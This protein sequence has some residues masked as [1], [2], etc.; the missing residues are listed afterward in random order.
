MLVALAWS[1]LAA[2]RAA[3]DAAAREAA[4]LRAR[5]DA[6]AAQSRTSSATSAAIS[7]PR[8]ASSAAAAAA[9]R[10][11]ARRSVAR[12][13]RRCS[14]SSPAMA[15]AQGEQ[16][17]RFGERLAE[18]TRTNEQ[19]LEAVRATVEQR[20][21]A[22]RNENAAKL[23][24]MR[25]T[26]DE[27]LQTT[28]EQRLGESFKQVSERL[29]QVHKGLGEMQTLAA[30]VGDLKRVLTNV[31]TRGSWGEVQLGALLEQVLTP[32]QYAAQ[33][34]DA[35]GQR[36]ARRV[37][38]PAARAR[39]TTA[40]RA[41]CRSTP[42]SRSRTTQRLQDAQERADLRRVRSGRA[43]A[44]RVRVTRRGEDDPR[45]VRRAAAHDRFRDPVPADRGA[46][47]RG[48]ARARA[49]PTRCS[50]SYRVMVAGPTTLAALL[51]SL[52]MG[53]RTLAIEQRSS[54]VW[55]VLGAVKTEFGKFGDVL[56]KT[57]KKL[58]QASKTIDDAGVRS[59]GDRPGSCAR[60]RRCPSPRRP[61]LYGDR[62]P[63]ADGDGDGRPDDA[64]PQT[65]R[66]MFD[67]LRKWRQR[68]GA[69]DAAIPDALWREAPQALPFLA[70]YDA[71]ELDAAAR[72]GRAVPRRQGDRR[73]ARSR[74]DAAAARVIALQACV[75]VLNLDLAYYDGFENVVVYPDEFVPGWE[76]EDEAG[77]VHRQRRGARRRGDAAGP[78][79]LS[80]PDVE[81]GADWDAAGMNLVIHEFAHK[82]DMRNGEANGCPPLPAGRCRRTSGRT[83]LGAAFDH[84]RARVRSRRAHGDRSLRGRE[85][86]RVLRGAVR[87]V[88]RRPGAAFATSTRGV[89]DQFARFYRQDPAAA[90]RR[91]AGAPGVLC[92]RRSGARA[93]RITAARISAPPASCT[94]A[95]VS[96]STTAASSTVNS[97]S[98][99]DSVDARVGPMRSRP[100]KNSV[101]AATVETS[102]M[103]TTASQPP[104]VCG[105][106][107]PRHA[108]PRRRTPTAALAMTTV[109]IAQ[110]RDAAA[111]RAR[112]RRCRRRRSPP[113][114]RRTRCRQD[115]RTR[116][117][118]VAAQRRHHRQRRAGQRERQRDELRAPSAAR[119]GT[120]RREQRDQRRMQVEEQ[121]D[122]AG[123][124]ERQRREER[125]RLAAVAE[126]AQ[127]D[128]RR[129]RRA[130]RQR[131]ARAR[132]SN[133]SMTT[134]A[135]AKRSASSVVVSTPDA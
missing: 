38:D 50:A 17:Q 127:H 48:D 115:A 92:Q 65:D 111:E 67:A 35:A 32:E 80:W 77:V 10:D 42:S 106:C 29:E 61:R 22:L 36:R 83:M 18:L 112:R 110:R 25:A 95:I 117:A 73:R 129:Q 98:T 46:L 119:A 78:V 40:R 118:R 15:T 122:E 51:N 41:G 24:Q 64:E 16:L 104:A 34:R 107:G 33:R 69:A 6:L 102:A 13:R 96:P 124:G 23:E 44:R 123:R 49:S 126:R 120:A 70:I 45:Q 116:A 63:P 9:A 2:L 21:D 59:A 75:L 125:E 109:A 99:V 91:G 85:P 28:L 114:R 121:R 56:A 113:R 79:M 1:R 108:A 57:K 133:A 26:V 62:R 4:E 87:G 101:I 3:R 88:L 68:A 20:L 19:R 134:A 89:Y 27:K 84:F 135:I 43:R 60:S 103:P 54:E 53:F 132:R 131:D 52:Q 72:E 76:W 39:P 90:E 58:D 5:V 11:R 7:R 66:A 93:S 55:K 31:K 74:G 86:G 81:A 130:A 14:S 128:E 37:R 105:Q 94:G 8:A 47:R 12:F 97:G 30:G 100:A 82:I 71:D